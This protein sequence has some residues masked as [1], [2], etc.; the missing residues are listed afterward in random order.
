MSERPYLIS[1]WRGKSNNFIYTLKVVPVHTY[2]DYHLWFRLNCIMFAGGELEFYL[3]SWGSLQGSAFKLM[4]WYHRMQR[5]LGEIFPGTY[6]RILSGLDSVFTA[7]EST[8]GK[9]YKCR[10]CGFFWSGILRKEQWVKITPC[11]LYNLYMERCRVFV[12]PYSCFA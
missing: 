1:I 5:E 12:L 4:N 2:L 6:I 9:I 7:R 3:S 10:G 8:R 11:S